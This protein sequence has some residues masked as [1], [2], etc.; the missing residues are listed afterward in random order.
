MTVFHDFGFT[1]GGSTRSGEVA[2]AHP[3]PR[4]RPA[5]S[6]LV[7][8]QTD[9]PTVG[10]VDIQKQYAET[11]EEIDAAIHAVVASGQF[12]GGSAVKRF[13]A[14]FAS[15][16]GTSHAVAVGNGT[17]AL[18]LALRALGIGPGDEVL[19]VAHTFVAT[20]A[21]ITLAGA[22]PVLCDIDPDTY[23]LDSE[24]AARRVTS[25]TKAILPVHLYGHTADMAPLLELADRHGLFVLED[26]AQAHGA[27]CRG[28]RAGGL[29]HAAA[30]SF[31]PSKNLGAYG[32]GGAV[33]TN[34]PAL[35]ERVRRLRNHGRIS[36]YEHADFTFNSQLDTLQA[37]ILSVQ[38][39][40]LARRNARRRALAAR[41]DARLRRVR[42]LALPQETEDAEHVYHL[43]VV[44][45]RH[46]DALQ[47]ALSAAGIE[48]GVHYPVPIHL[49][50]AW[51]AAFPSAAGRG[52]FPTIERYAGEILSLPMHPHLS[53]A[54][55]DHV[56]D[57]VAAALT[58]A[59][60][61]GG[62]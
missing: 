8:R 13:E 32:D 10:F 30:F 21:A 35:A 53:D 19:T 9:I 47:T 16:C 7:S 45:T 12:V 51:A 24:D 50:P 42:G 46:R 54:Q 48:W 3:A 36:K 22:V 29:G 20:V 49:Q 33:T 62:K 44:R 25:R 18:H 1:N 28:R 15:Y 23:C 11:S 27:R 31:Y 59:E 37:A 60:N 57:V 5:V 58:R 39:R 61:G 56:A 14:E 38:L 26:A 2:D 17:D 34:D 40:H 43:Y 55:I 6:P 52:L 4:P 41:Y